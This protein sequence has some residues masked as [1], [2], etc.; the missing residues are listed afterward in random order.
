M[1]L[2]NSISY[3]QV[4]RALNAYAQRLTTSSF[5]AQNLNKSLLTKDTNLTFL[6][7]YQIPTLEKLDRNEML[8]E[9]ITEKVKQT[10]IPLRLTYN[11][12][13]PNSKLIRKH[14]NLLAINE[15][16]KEILTC[17]Q[18]TAFKRNKNLKEQIGS[19]KIE[20]NKYL[21]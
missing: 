19:N 18:I 9:R 2:K 17:Q 3:S 5:I 1:P 15:S 12:F 13:C 11:R 7:K 6:I 10:R 4:L 16:L 20:K 14:W 21:N 8:K